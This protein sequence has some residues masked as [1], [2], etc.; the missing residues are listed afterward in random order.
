MAEKQNH[1]FRTFTIVVFLLMAGALPLSVSPSVSASSP[2]T[3]NMTF[4]MHY[5]SNPPQVGGVVTNYVIDTRNNFQSAKNS[6]FKGSGQPKLTLDWYIAPSFAGPVGLNGVW[7]T[8]I[9]A[10]S[11]ALHPATWG[12]EFWEKSPTGAVVW[13]SGALSPTVLGGPSGNNGYLDSP[14]YAYSLDV[15][16][17]H[18]FATGNT[19]QVEININSGATVPIRVWYDSSSHSSRLVLPSNDYARVT[20]LITHDANGTARNTFF[21]FWPQSQRIVTVVASITD[22]FGGYDI[23]KVLVQITGPGGFLAVNNASMVLSSGTPTSYTSFYQYAYSYTSSQAEGTYSVLGSVVDN[24]GEI[25]FEKTGSYSPFIE[26][27]TTNFSIGVQFPV[28]I[29]VLDSHNRPLPSAFVQFTQGGLDYVS[30]RTASNGILNIT[31]FTG[32]FVVLVTW[33]GVVVARQTVDVAHQTTITIATKVY[34]P[35]FVFQSSDGAKIQGILAFVTYP[36]GTTGRLPFVTD[37]AGSFLPS[38]QP[39]GNYSLLGFLEGVK[40]ADAT[41]NVTSDGPFTVRASVFNLTVNVTDGS[42]HAL[43]NATV[44]LQ[45]TGTSNALVYRYGRTATSGIVSFELP[46]G[47]YR[48]TAEYYDVFWLTLARNST[49]VTI[50]LS[51]DATVPITMKNIPPPIW[52]TLGF[53]LIVAILAVIVA[54]A[55]LFLRAKRGRTR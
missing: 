41:T 13:D 34:Y 6:D 1:K 35:A 36:N 55:F 20:S 42:H 45:G 28:T 40:V 9:F 8:I 22:P 25:Q 10:N 17:N 49:T 51:S 53:Q 38:Q 30:G 27:G 52:S 32:T 5:T 43:S 2:I 15:N 46:V 50:H 44:F 39:A 16:L 11:T 7:Q 54:A 21:S 14:V 3:K 4:Y 33:E 37:G 23:A 31:I 47:D 29:K 48:V 26:Y 19:L 18:S 12:V 24:N